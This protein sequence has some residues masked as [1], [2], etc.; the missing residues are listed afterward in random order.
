MSE[1]KSRKLKVVWNL[2][3][4]P[5]NI[6]EDCHVSRGIWSPEDFGEE[7]FEQW[8]GYFFEEEPGSKILIEH[9]QS[10]TSKFNYRIT[11]TLPLSEA[12]SSN[13]DDLWFSPAYIQHDDFAENIDGR[14]IEA[15][16][17]LI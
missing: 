8:T 12:N 11:L 9:L 6:F 4:L 5:E 10:K 2:D 14:E 13:R 16:F 7:I 15:D 17:A 3:R 1:S